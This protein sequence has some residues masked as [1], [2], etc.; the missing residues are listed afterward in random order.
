MPRLLPALLAGAA[1]SGCVSEQTAT[2][3]PISAAGSEPCTT[4]ERAYRSPIGGRALGSFFRTLERQTVPISEA[5]RA[6]LDDTSRAVYEVVE[7]FY[8]PPA[9]R[10]A[11]GETD[12]AR[13][14]ARRTRYSTFHTGTFRYV[15]ARHVV[16]PS[17]ISFSPEHPEGQRADWSDLPNR[18]FGLWDY[19]DPDNPPAYR[20]FNPARE[21]SLLRFRPRLTA[22]PGQ[23]L[24]YLT[25]DDVRGLGCFLDRGYVPVGSRGI[26][27]TATPL[28]ESANRAQMLRPY[29]TLVSGHWGGWHV[30]TQPI[31]HGLVVNRAL[32]EAAVT[33]RLGYRGGYALYRKQ[34]GIWVLDRETLT[35]IE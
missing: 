27:S 21:D 18:S 24:L 2:Q 8:D 35:W 7:A 17:P 23:R 30:Q 5:E 20:L 4:L 9:H 16:A 3:R 12:Y 10:H 33:F 14:I 22:P 32:D 13:E 19:V 25:D 29:L 26:I 31:V 1:L 15:I 11:L 6:A 34:A 28:P